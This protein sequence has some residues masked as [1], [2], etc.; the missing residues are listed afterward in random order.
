MLFMLI[1]SV[2]IVFCLVAQRSGEK[3]DAEL[4]AWF[5]KRA[6]EGMKEQLEKLKNK[7][8]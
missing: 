8:K 6:Q 2:G 4:R 7:G 1:I 3:Q 5:K